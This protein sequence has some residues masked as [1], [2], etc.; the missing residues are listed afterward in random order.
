MAKGHLTRAGARYTAKRITQGGIATVATSILGH[1]LNTGRYALRDTANLWERCQDYL[2]FST[3]EKVG[4]WDNDLQTGLMAFGA[5]YAFKETT[6]A[7]NY[8]V[9]PGDVHGWLASHAAAKKAAAKRA[10]K[11]KK[12]ENLRNLEKQ[13]SD[14]ETEIK[15]QKG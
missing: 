6:R 3:P 8:A 2:L 14:L 13:K 7:W 12:A 4:V 5:I 15:V 10:E 9:D 1:I 11:E